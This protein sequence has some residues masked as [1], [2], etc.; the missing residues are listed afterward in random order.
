MEIK[1][2]DTTSK[3]IMICTVM[4]LILVSGT[5]I[6]ASRIDAVPVNK[7]NGMMD[8]I[9]EKIEDGVGDSDNDGNPNVTDPDKSENTNQGGDNSTGPQNGS[10]SG[11]GNGSGAGTDS[12]TGGAD[13]LTSN[14]PT[15]TD[16]QTSNPETTTQAENSDVLEDENSGGFNWWGILIAVAIAAAVVI[17]IIAL[18]PKK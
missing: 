16:P 3:I 2:R 14:T 1:M 12:A 18:L 17:L 7:R 13:P 9:R 10:D 4:A 15:T 6:F 8:R 11:A 5:Q